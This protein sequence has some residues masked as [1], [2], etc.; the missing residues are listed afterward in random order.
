MPTVA[1]I[2]RRTTPAEQQKLAERA[3]EAIKSLPE[4]PERVAALG[5]LREGLVGSGISDVLRAQI[6]T[7]LSTIDLTELAL[8]RLANIVSV[9]PAEGRS[10]AVQALLDRGQ[11]IHPDDWAEL[12][13]QLA[14]AAPT[15]LLTG[16]L[17]SLAPAGAAARMKALP[18]LAAE[19]AR[20]GDDEIAWSAWQQTLATAE[21]DP[22]W[23]FLEELRH[24]LPLA[25]RIWG[26][27]MVPAVRDVVQRVAACFP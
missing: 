13:A 6:E 17:S 16:L 24:A 26:N 3:F 23:H 8:P 27:E 20:R 19:I 7:D 25:A 5:A 1:E 9:L 18:P 14:P 4:A 22:R 15:H 12:A 2:L 10:A 21:R 11:A